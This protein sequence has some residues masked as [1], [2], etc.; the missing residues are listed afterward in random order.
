MREGRARNAEK[1]RAVG[2]I[3]HEFEGLKADGMKSLA[4]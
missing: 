3:I 4:Y 1:R 2:R